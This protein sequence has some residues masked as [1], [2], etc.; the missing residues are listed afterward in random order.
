[1]IAQINLSTTDAIKVVTSALDCG[2]NNWPKWS[3]NFKD[4]LLS[5]HA[6]PYVLGTIN[7]P[8]ETADSLSA[9]IWDVNNKAIVVTMHGHCTLKEKL[10]LIGQTNTFQVWNMLHEH[11]KQISLVAQ[12]NVIQKLLQACYKRNE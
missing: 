7:Q 1:M 8:M 11:H 3:V 4:Y 2:S 12:I 6:W 10:F 5:K 9:A